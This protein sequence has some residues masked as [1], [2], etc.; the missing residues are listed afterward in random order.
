MSR[1][2]VLF[3]VGRLVAGSVYKPQTTD[4]DG[5]PL[6]VKNGPNK[7]QPRVDYFIAV[8]I[9][10]IAGHTH[11]AQT[12]WGEI[13][14]KTGHA[15]HGPAAQRPDFAWK[16]TDGDSAAP[17]KKGVAPRTRE[18]YIGHW[19]VNMGSS[20][21]PKIYNADGSQQI[22]TPDAVKAGY[23]VQVAGSVG[24]NE[25]TQNPGVFINHGMVALA[26]FGPEI[27]VG[28]DPKTVGFGG[29]LPA[30]ASAVPLSGG[31]NP[32]VP[33]AAVPG[34][35]V[36]FP[37]PPVATPLP[38]AAPPPMQV[39]APNPGFLAAPGPVYAPVP[40]VPPV[41]TP[42]AVP[43]APARWMTPLAQ[44]ATYEQM[45]AQG[46]TDALLWKHGM[47]VA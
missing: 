32:A 18:G 36:G 42:P 26:G 2:N 7:G 38:P 43:T 19:V 27:I 41:M 13:I 31:F 8:A 21:A 30:G 44:G 11:W 20:Y 12:P 22:V 39:V 5:N 10:K 46:W 25:S 37:A 14:W 40:G 1:T 17:N 24:G 9:P 15:E 16:I 29:A 34:A 33:G 6:L 23:W 3:P 35:P 47:M 45:I 28:P 4:A